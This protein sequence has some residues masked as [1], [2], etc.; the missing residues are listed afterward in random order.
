MVS[1][2]ELKTK[3]NVDAKNEAKVKHKAETMAEPELEVIAVATALAPGSRSQVDSSLVSSHSAKADCCF[4][5]PRRRS[6]R[7]ALVQS[8]GMEHHCLA[9]LF[10]WKPPHYIE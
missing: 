2:V 10:C 4:C 9:H 8:T 1:Q 5:F 3:S 7:Q 6:M